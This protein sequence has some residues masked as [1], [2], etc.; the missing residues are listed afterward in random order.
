MFPTLAIS[1]GDNSMQEIEDE[2]AQK[3]KE[4]E[5]EKQR[6]RGREKRQQASSA[7]NGAAEASLS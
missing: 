2:G 6:E 1:W 3:E 4:R 5:R 7:F